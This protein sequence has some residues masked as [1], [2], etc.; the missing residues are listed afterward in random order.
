MHIPPNGCVVIFKLRKSRLEAAPTDDKPNFINLHYL[1]YWSWERLPAAICT[2]SFKTKSTFI[3]HLNLAE[4]AAG[5]G[6][7]FNRGAGIDGFPDDIH[8]WVAQGNAGICSTIDF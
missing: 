6:S 8:V 2:L 1:V 7:D 4:S 3:E 5:L